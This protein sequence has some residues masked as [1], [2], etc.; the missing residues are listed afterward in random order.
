MAG[1]GKIAVWRSPIVK[2]A[3]LATASLCVSSIAGAVEPPRPAPVGPF[4]EAI[5]TP[6]VPP[7]SMR[8]GSPQPGSPEAGPPFSAPLP[9]AV[10]LPPR[11]PIGVAIPPPPT[12]P[13]PFNI[14]ERPGFTPFPAGGLR[15]ALAEY[16]RREGLGASG[17]IEHAIRVLAMSSVARGTAV[18][19]IRAQASGQIAAV[20]VTAANED[21]EA[22][23]ELGERLT[24]LS[25]LPLRLPEEA[26]GVWMV[27]RV[28]ARVVHPAG[29]R[30]IYPGTLLAFDPSNIA[31]RQLRVVHAQT[32]SELWF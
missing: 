29:D 10:P 16:D 11:A 25:V 19:A 2:A 5:P 23:R 18:F 31:T 21:I 12:V 27:I 3:I 28:E 1:Q 6:A 24:T 22:W 9:P 26:N 30:S 8:P 17:P 4:D 7:P 20:R 15:Q 14:P 32:L 13:P